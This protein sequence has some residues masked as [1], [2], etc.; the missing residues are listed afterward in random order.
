M[1]YI[2]KVWLNFNSNLVAKGLYLHFN[3]VIINFI[4]TFI[5]KPQLSQLDSCC[6]T[7]ISFLFQNLAAFFSFNLITLY[8]Y[9]I[10]LQH[11]FIS[12]FESWYKNDLISISFLLQHHFIQQQSHFIL[13]VFQ[14]KSPETTRLYLSFVGT[15]ND[16]NFSP[17]LLWH[18][19]F[20]VL[21]CWASNG[22]VK[23][24]GCGSAF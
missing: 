18:N 7:T 4:S 11:N 12:T 9:F 14:L 16:F 5:L 20:I 24:R 15:R 1:F 6:H 3:L 13:T 19:D 22:D 2:V 8:S 23:I 17:V 10:S 21:K